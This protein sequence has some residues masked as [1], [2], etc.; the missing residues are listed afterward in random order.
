MMQ[1]LIKTLIFIS[2]ILAILAIVSP[3]LFEG[4]GS[5]YLAGYLLF[6]AALCLIVAL[7]VYLGGVLIRESLTVITSGP[8]ASL[9]EG[10]LI[11]RC[12]I[13]IFISIIFIFL[14]YRCSSGIQIFSSKALLPKNLEKVK[15]LKEEPS[16]RSYVL[17]K[18]SKSSQWPLELYDSVDNSF[19]LRNNRSGP[20][21][22][23]RI[24]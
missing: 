18:F 17:K 23:V 10:S 13:I 3:F 20:N 15:E 6:A 22:F 7:M 1:L 4:V 11:L 8:G 14:A 16:S 21:R 24:D 19:I 5:V 2:V 12:L 9:L